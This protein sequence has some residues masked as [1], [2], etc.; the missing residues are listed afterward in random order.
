[1]E[2]GKENG[3]KMVPEMVSKQLI[4]SCKK[5]GNGNSLGSNLLHVHTA[6]IFCVILCKRGS[7]KVTETFGTIIILDWNQVN[8]H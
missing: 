4:E 2:N 3:D 1:M 7:Q 8:Y 6:C 5:N